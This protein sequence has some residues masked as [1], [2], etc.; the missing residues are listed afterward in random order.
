VILPARPRH[1]S[2]G[3]HE[4]ENGICAGRPEQQQ[5]SSTSPERLVPAGRACWVALGNRRINFRRPTTELPFT[6]DRHSRFL[7]SGLD[8]LH[9]KRTDSD[10]DQPMD[11]SSVSFGRLRFSGVAHLHVPHAYLYLRHLDHLLSQLTDC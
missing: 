10:A 8:D 4:D 1:H 2:L 9:C 3:D 5:Q 6:Y 7:F 11:Y